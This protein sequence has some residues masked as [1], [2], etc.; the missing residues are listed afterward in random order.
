MES[1]ADAEIEVLSAE[2]LWVFSREDYGFSAERGLW[3]F[4]REFYGFSAE[5]GL[6]V[7][8]REDCGFSADR[9]SVSASV[10]LRHGESFSLPSQ[11]W[12]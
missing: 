6:L 12:V 11:D 2:N 8:S 3:V 7:F 10:E 9:T 1:S 5:K 4:S